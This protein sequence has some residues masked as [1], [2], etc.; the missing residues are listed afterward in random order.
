MN[1][2]NLRMIKKVKLLR[3]IQKAKHIT[4]LLLTQKVEEPLNRNAHNFDPRVI[5]V[6]HV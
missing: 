1:A 4:K 3:F 2:I 5:S 6:T